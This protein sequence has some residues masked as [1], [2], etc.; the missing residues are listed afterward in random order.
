MWLA[1]GSQCVAPLAAANPL[2]LTLPGVPESE[3]C[4]QIAAG[5]LQ[6]LR[7]FRQAGG[8]QVTLDEFGLSALLFLAQDPMIIEAVVHRA[9]ANEKQTAE[10]EHYLALEK[11]AIVNH[12]LTQ[13]GNRMPTQKDSPTDFENARQ[14]LSLCEA[15]MA[16]GDYAMASAHARRAMLPLRKLERAAWEAAMKDRDSPVTIPGTSSFASLPWYWALVD[17]IAAM[18][19]GP[20]RLPGGDFENRPQMESYGWRHFHHPTPGIQTTADLMPEA[21]HSGRT[22]LRL[23]ARADNPEYPPATIEMP[24]MWI[25]SP[26]IPVQAGQI[27]RIHG[28]V[29]VPAAITGS[30]DGLMVVES[31]TGEEMALR[32]DKTV[33][34]REFTM[35]RIVPQSGPLY[36]TLAMTGLGEVRLDDLAIEI[37]EPSR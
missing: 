27:V 7:H 26:A 36:I 11:L 1:P 14:N 8:T 24:P 4:F 23:I 34:W 17:R 10:L 32:L 3:Y 9:A 28:W 29:N 5:R 31:L 33:G 2:K 19:P 37:L 35:L 25:T 16:S 6:P 20:N 15:R 30:V 18:R 22:G 13:I 12:V 21:A